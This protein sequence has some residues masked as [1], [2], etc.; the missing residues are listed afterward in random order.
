MGPPRPL[1]LSVPAVAGRQFVVLPMHLIKGR[2]YTVSWLVQI[3]VIATSD[4]RLFIHAS[5]VLPLL[6]T[7]LPYKTWRSRAGLEVE[8]SHTDR[9]TV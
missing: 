9:K 2:A 1:S 4:L 3:K 8:E 5:N 7:P 6:P